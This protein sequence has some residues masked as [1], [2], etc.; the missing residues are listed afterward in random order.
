MRP[1]LLQ[2]GQDQQDGHIDLYDEFLVVAGEDGGHLADDEEHEG[3]QEHRHHVTG[4]RSAESDVHEHSELL[5]LV[6]VAVTD[7]LEDVLEQLSGSGVDNVQ[8]PE[9]DL[10]CRDVEQKWT[11]LGVN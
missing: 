5:L 2:C 4:Q 11:V 9:S 10:L 7:C 1:E 3:G 8:A 6:D